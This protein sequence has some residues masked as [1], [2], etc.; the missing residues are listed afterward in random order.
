MLV[1]DIEADGLL[2]TVTCIHCIVTY[3][4]ELHTTRRYFDSTLPHGS[5]LPWGS[6]AE[7]IDALKKADAIICHNQYGY[8]LP[9]IE[10]ITGVDLSKH[11]VP[12]DTLI[13]SQL[14]KPD[15]PSHSLEYWAGELK[16]SVEKVANE[17]WSKLTENMLDRCVADV[18]INWKVYGYLQSCRGDS[19]WVVAYRLEAEVVKLHNKQVKHGVKFD[20]V[21]AQKLLELFDKRIKEL[22]DAIESGAPLQQIIPWKRVKDAYGIL[23]NVP[24]TVDRV[25][26]KDMSLQPGVAKYFEGCDTKVVGPHSRVTWRKINLNS[27]TEVKG[28]LLKEGW[29]PS[30]YTD[31]DSPK[32]TEE[33]VGLEDS[34][35]GAVFKELNVLKHRR[36]FLLG[37]P[38]KG[39]AKGALAQV[40]RKD[41]R[42]EARAITCGTPTARYRHSG[43]VCNIPRPGTLYGKEIR[44]LF[45]VGEGHLLVGTDLCG[46]EAR[47]MAHYCYNYPGGIALAERVLSMDKTNDF[48]TSN[49][50]AWGVDRNTAKSGLY[51][52]C[53]GC[54]DAKLA[55]TLGKPKKEGKRLKALFWDNNPA[56]K[57]LVSDLERSL[58]AHEGW[59]KG[60]DGRKVFI[61]ESRKLLNSLLQN[62][63]AI[64]F[65]QW[66]VNCDQEK[67]GVEAHQVIAYHDE[68]QD[69]LYTSDVREAHT[70]GKR[71]CELAAIT[72]EQLNL[73]VPIAA[74]Y[75]V[76]KNWAET[77]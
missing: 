69:E 70:Y 64:V 74:E 54:G 10:Q 21:K 6:V 43:A 23:E 62:S 33:L 60:L 52:L 24:P 5:V 71:V 28:W 13:L 18:H 45:C 48:H 8:D 27:I 32:L 56:L 19:D 3:D 37:K 20:V 17:D 41:N 61:R 50:I 47:M 14:L 4:T 58:K 25:F 15:S 66:M 55:N 22:T 31:K 26:K 16:L 1:Y 2:D 38:I 40:R 36:R 68:K 42:V 30:A 46:I 72:G 44:E 9:A 49:G 11:T 35:L 51:A 34:S 59:I 57:A 67:F 7:G 77:H 65:K 76:G 53:Y 12:V 73:N 63:A 39:V 29:K 75:K